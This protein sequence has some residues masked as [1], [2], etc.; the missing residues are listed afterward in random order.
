MSGNDIQSERHY[1]NS[2][3]ESS[4]YELSRKREKEE[5]PKQDIK[6]DRGEPSLPLALVLKACPDILPY[7]QYEPR[8]WRDLVALAALVRGMLGI[9]SD[10]WHDAQETMGPETAAI[11]VAGILQ[12][13]DD[14]RSPGGYLRALSNKARIGPF[15]PG[16]M[17]MALL[18]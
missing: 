1:S 5:P 8:T 11:C 9:S 10:A 12:K 6:V 16:P 7:A 3:K 2:N 13:V 15:S 18:H 4:D 14:I 17:V